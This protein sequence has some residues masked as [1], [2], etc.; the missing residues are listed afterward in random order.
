[1]YRSPIIVKVI[2]SR[3]WRWAGHVARMGE[4]NSDFKMLTSKSTGKSIFGRP[5]R[6][7]S[8]ILEWIFKKIGFNKRNWVDLA[9][10]RDYCRVLVN[11]AF[12]LRVP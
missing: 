12:N 6:R 5:R 8:T 2:K 11:T 10:N 3:R 9:Q 7:W 4:G 1:M